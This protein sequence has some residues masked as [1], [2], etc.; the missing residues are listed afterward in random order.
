MGLTIPSHVACIVSIL[1]SDPRALA[2]SD[3]FERTLLMSA[4]VTVVRQLDRLELLTKFFTV[5][6]GLATNRLS[7]DIRE[8]MGPPDPTVPPTH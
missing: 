5:S 7:L 2:P 6:L 1:A 4:G 8:A 3:E